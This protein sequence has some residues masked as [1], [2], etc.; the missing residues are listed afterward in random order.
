MAWPRVQDN[1]RTAQFI[2]TETLPWLR[3][4][5]RVFGRFKFTD[6]WE[7]VEIAGEPV[8]RERRT[9]RFTTDKR[10]PGTIA[11]ISKNSG[12]KNCAILF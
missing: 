2:Q 1:R 9:D 4:Q 7:Q 6:G 8:L 5:S 3:P 11:S 10:L 12:L